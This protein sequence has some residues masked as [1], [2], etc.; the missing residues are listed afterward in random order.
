MYTSLRRK[1]VA[2]WSPALGP[3]GLR[4][5]DNVSNL[6]HGTLQNFG[7]GL[8][9]G[10]RRWLTFTNG[11]RVPCRHSNQI[12]FDITS[13][14]SYS[15]WCL[16]STTTN[17]AFL[18]KWDAAS[19]ARGYYMLNGSTGGGNVRAFIQGGTG[20]NY[21]EVDGAINVCNGVPNHVLFTYNG[22]GVAAGCNVYI[23]G[24][25]DSLTTVQD[26]L[27]GTSQTTVDLT[28]GG[29]RADANSLAYTGK[30]TDILIWRR[31]LTQREAVLLYS[32]G[33]GINVA[34]V[35]ADPAARKSVEA[36]A[37]GLSI[38]IADYHYRH[39]GMI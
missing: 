4:L 29:R 22:S 7:S 26:T 38:P 13:R 31:E 28:L 15:F 2:G 17:M 25:K 5:N 34:Y 6:H 36:A 33:K 39:H 21:I 20:T 12:N 10:T 3:Q 18:G 35:V 23:N 19:S 8:G 9:W 14:F 16:T 32:H 27:S 11:Q 30:L 37:G 1:L 24:V